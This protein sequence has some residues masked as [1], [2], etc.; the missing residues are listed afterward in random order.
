MS[1]KLETAA[2]LTG[3]ELVITRV[4]DAPRELVFRAWVDEGQLSRWWGPKG[5]TTPVCEWDARTGGMIHIDMRGPDGTIYP[6]SGKFTEIIEPSKIV[7]TASA[8]DDKGEA[9]FENLNTVTFSEQGG[10]T[11]MKL[12]VRVLSAG[13]EAAKHLNGMSAGWNQSLDRFTDLLARGAAENTQNRE[14][15]MSREFDAP[16]DLVWR[17]MTDP[18]QV[19]KWWGPRGFSTT[20]QEMDVRPG[21][22]WN[23]VMHG[24]DGTDYPNQSVFTEIVK[25]QRICFSHGGAKKGGPAANFQATWSFDSLDAGA[26]TRVT[27]HMVFPTAQE[28]DTVVKVYGAIEG[29]N[30]TLARLA[31]ELAKTPVVI[32]RTFDAP[33]AT[34]WKAITEIDQMRKWYFPMLEAFEPRVGFQTQFNVRVDEKD[35]LHIWKIT[36]VIAGKK[37]TYSWKFGGFPGESF[38]TFELF[39]EGNRTRLKLTHEGLETF[40]PDANPL[41]SRGNFAK[42][43]THFMGAALAE[44]LAKN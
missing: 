24:P 23:H 18:K 28:R 36:E 10:K 40:L 43:W 14:I 25:P 22:V 39:A 38:L 32:E 34:V 3:R 1:A 44:Y 4:F 33:V 35:Y 31:E 12:H 29:G 26:R 11:T 20:I 21:G 27:I 6:M 15:L 42:G 16:R 41:L 17:A 13:P 2:E 7:F 9:K 30:Q 19:V 37:I 8:L 5:F